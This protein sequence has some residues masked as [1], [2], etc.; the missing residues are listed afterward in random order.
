MSTQAHLDAAAAHG[1][2]RDNA[3]YVQ[4]QAALVEHMF[5]QQIVAS[6]NAAMIAVTR[7]AGIDLSLGAP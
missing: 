3:G 7:R 5:D 4:L 6:M 1:F 2:S